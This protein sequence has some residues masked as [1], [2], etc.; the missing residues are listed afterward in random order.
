MR[1]MQLAPMSQVPGMP[2]SRSSILQSLDAVG[3][4]THYRVSGPR[5]GIKSM[6]GW[7]V[8]TTHAQRLESLNSTS[9]AI[10]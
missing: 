2:K 4:N 1:I 7:G 9:Q 5:E 10:I 8:A 6:S 3:L